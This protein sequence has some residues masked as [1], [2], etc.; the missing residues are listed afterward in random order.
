MKFGFESPTNVYFI[1]YDSQHCLLIRP[2]LVSV[3]SFVVFW[4]AFL[5][6]MFVNV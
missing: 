1:S 3:R 4:G 2:E 5:M 6:A